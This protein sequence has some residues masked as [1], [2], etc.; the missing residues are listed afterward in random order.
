MTKSNLTRCPRKTGAASDAQP[1]SVTK[2]DVA[3]DAKTAAPAHEESVPPS[4]K[5]PTGKL[6][7]VVALLARAEGATVAQ[8]SAATDWQGHSVRGAIAGALKKKHRLTV[9]SEPTEGGRVYRLG[10]SAQ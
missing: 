9:L 1:R 4:S 10:E 6:G 5:G 7:I 2:K 8:I 3:A